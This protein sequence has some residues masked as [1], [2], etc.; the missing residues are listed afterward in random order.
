LAETDI[1][2]IE[3]MQ[4]QKEQVDPKFLKSFG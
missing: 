3:M 2:D 1:K 4:P